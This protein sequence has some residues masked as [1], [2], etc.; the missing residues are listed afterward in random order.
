MR[1]ERQKT[2]DCNTEEEEEE[3]EEEDF[4]EEEEEEAFTVGCGKKA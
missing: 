4:E 2:A 1:E 3:E